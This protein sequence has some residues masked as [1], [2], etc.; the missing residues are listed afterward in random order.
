MDRAMISGELP[1]EI[2]L[3]AKMNKFKFKLRKFVINSLFT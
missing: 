1:E 3:E 2:H